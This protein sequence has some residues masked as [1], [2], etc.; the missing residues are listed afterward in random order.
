MSD[1]KGCGKFLCNHPNTTRCGEKVGGSTGC[2]GNCLPTCQFC[3]GPV[4]E[5]CVAD[6]KGYIC[7]NCCDVFNE[8][9]AIQ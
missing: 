9:G 5:D 8:Q 1:I 6:D 4:N 7:E 2:C 3:D